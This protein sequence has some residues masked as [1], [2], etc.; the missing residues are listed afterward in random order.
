MIAQALSWLSRAIW[1]MLL[2]AL[3]WVLY[4]LGSH[5]SSCRADGT[6]KFGCLLS[7]LIFGWLDILLLVLGA[8][9]RVLTAVLP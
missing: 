5:Y 4:V 1:S 7:A 8:V 6:G 9:V 3:V 2:V